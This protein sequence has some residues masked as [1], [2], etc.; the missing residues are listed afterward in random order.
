MREQAER[1]RPCFDENVLGKEW[2]N[3]SALETWLHQQL[4]L[5]LLRNLLSDSCLLVALPDSA[6]R[7]QPAGKG[8]C[9]RQ[10]G[11]FGQGGSDSSC[12]DPRG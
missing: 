12:P 3:L 7:E 6:G 9:T 10:S 1:C 8:V 4:L 5:L 2:L 11:D